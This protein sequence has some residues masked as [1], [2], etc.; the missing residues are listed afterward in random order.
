M[1]TCTLLPLAIS[2]PHII[3]CHKTICH[4]WT[5]S[6]GIHSSLGT[7]HWHNNAWKV[8]LTMQ[9]NFISMISTSWVWESQA[10]YATK[11]RSSM[12]STSPLTCVKMHLTYVTWDSHTWCRVCALIFVCVLRRILQPTCNKCAG[13]INKLYNEGLI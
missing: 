1:D 8:H 9:K 2:C 10:T 6:L 3:H 7:F 5:L 13:Q 11:E 12:L 4:T